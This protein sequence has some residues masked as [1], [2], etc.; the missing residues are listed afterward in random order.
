MD[1]LILTSAEIT[2]GA[3]TL[4]GGKLKASQVEDLVSTFRS[5]LGSLAGNYALKPTF[6]ALTDTADSNKAAKLAACLLRWQDNA[7]DVSAF[8]ATNANRTGFTDSTPGEN[9][10]IFKYAFGLFWDFPIEL[11]NRWLNRSNN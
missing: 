6:E 10:E 8:A 9:F 7:F 1:G 4:S 5:Y 2:A 11:E 3:G